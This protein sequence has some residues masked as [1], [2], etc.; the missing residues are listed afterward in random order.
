MSWFQLDPQSIADRARAAVSTVPSLKASLA[1]GIVGFTVVSL[2]GFVPWAVFGRW[3][4]KHIG[5]AGLYACCA[6]VFIGLSGP[7]M[8]RLVIGPGSL[9]RF[10]KL[11]GLSFAA[12]S[13]AWIV[14]WLALR[15]HPGSLAGLFAGTAIMGWMLVT[16]FD[17]RGELIKVTGSLFVLNSLGYFIG[18]EVEGWLIRWHPLTAKLMWGFCYGIG[19]GAGLGVAFYLCQSRA[20]ALLDE[21]SKTA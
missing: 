20:R 5:E 3:F 18:G 7:L 8:H 2:A 12:Y 13:V 17:A 15:G 16:A 19:F 14:G 21:A 10:Y 6:L 1:R 4:Y 9:T 11:F